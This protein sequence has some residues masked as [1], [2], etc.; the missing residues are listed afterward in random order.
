MECEI[1][2][3]ACISATSWRH[4]LSCLVWRTC[5]P[6]GQATCEARRRLRLT[7]SNTS[8]VAAD[9]DQCIGQAEVRGVA[10][11]PLLGRFDTCMRKRAYLIDEP[12][13]GG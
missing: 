6:R 2:W 1:T 5:A 7:T 13:K 9:V 8:P 10:I 11:Q 3:S 4:A 12:P